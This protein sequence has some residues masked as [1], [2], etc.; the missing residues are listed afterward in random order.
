VRRR[1]AL[2]GAVVA[3]LGLLVALF[4]ARVARR[5]PGARLEMGR[6]KLSRLTEE[7]RRRLGSLEDRVLLTYYASDRARMPS[8]LRRVERDV[9]DLFEA[10]KGASRERL[11]YQIV[12]PDADPVARDDLARFAAKRAVAPF[13]ARSV[14]RDAW[15]EK[16]VWSTISIAYGPRPES[17]IPGVGPEHLERLQRLLVEHLDQMERPR[18]A[19]IALAAPAGYEQL[20]GFLAQKG[21][22]RTVDLDGGERI[23]P[24]ADCLFWMDPRRVDDARLAEL[25]RFLRRGRNA[26]LAGSEHSW[27][28][29]RGADGA[30]ALT[31]EPTGYPAG[32]L[33]AH[34]GLRA[35][36]GL[37]CDARGEQAYAGMAPESRP[38][39]TPFVVRCI[40]VD[41][42]FRG[43]RNQPNGNL[44][45]EVPTPFALDPE[46]LEERGWQ[47]EVLA[48][49][50]DKSWVEPLPRGP[51]PFAALRPEA[52]EP[53]PKQPLMVRLKPRDPW[54]G[55]VVLCAASTPFRD[56]YLQ[57]REG[58]AH[59]RL[60]RVLADAFTA[61]DRLVL[62]RAG[63]LAVEPIPAMGARSRAL[64][65]AFA[66]LLLPGALLAVAL[67][68]GAFARRGEP[69]PRRR[70][71]GPLLA[72][73]L[74]GVLVV[75]LLARAAGAFG[76]RADL[77][78]SGRNELSPQT[79]AIAARASEPVEAKIVFSP[80]ERLPP[81]MRRWSKR[82]GEALAEL[83]RAG[84]RLSVRT[85]DPDEL[86]EAE[87]KTLAAEGIEPFRVTT[88]DEE[89][90]TVRTVHA[91]LRLSS[92]GRTEVLRFRDAVSIENLEFRLA[93]AL[94]RLETGR[95]PL[96]AF[97]SD[98][99]RLSPAEAWDLQQAS[100]TPPSG[101]DAYAVARGLLEGCDY[102][103]VHVNPR[104][105]RP[106]E[107]PDAFVWLQP[108]RDVS[109]TYDWLARYL[110]RG[111]R[112]LLAAQHFNVQA[113]QY[114]GSGYK[115]VY[116]PQPQFPDVDLLYFPDLGIEMVRE[117]L[118]D[119]LKT[120]IAAETQ[121]NRAYARPDLE[122]Q[123]S[124]LPFLLRASAANFSKDSAVTRS[125]G[126]QAF[127]WGAYVR[128]DEAKL[129]A[130][131]LR[132]KPLITT[133]ARTWTFPWK[134]GWIPDEALAGP[135][136]GEGGQPSWLGK[137]ALAAE[138]EGD[139]PEPAEP[140]RIQ[141]KIFPGATSEPAASKPAFAASTPGAPGRLLLLGC[142][143]MFKNHRV[144]DPEF[145][146]DHLLLNAVASLAL[147]EDLAEIA[148]RRP[149]QR[150]FDFVE[151]QDRLRWR[152]IVL[153]GLPAA[154][155]LFGFLRAVARRRPTWVATP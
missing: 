67:L 108:R 138:I 155:L 50:S 54:E 43:W 13:R 84:A 153:A 144:L 102:R 98:A 55:A 97:A 91:A 45:F 75:G 134:G 103:V 116:W 85:V 120:R 70:A 74:A 16:T 133:S 9:T 140:L 73:A 20:R 154:L 96:V 111:G 23:P 25:D 48:T 19:A 2:E 127:V 47:A 66:V 109:A 60:A 24:D 117:V 4:D 49:S 69:S 88:K 123:T 42:D 149:E 31:V 131:G 14:E 21:E 38:A 129:R 148:A 68:R 114:R 33:L 18:R 110:H 137:L 136:R 132:A 142:S 27:E 106:P 15:S 135:P 39:P 1:G 62:A 89:V 5:F 78:E 80:P 86:D 29:R 82:I 26:L 92:R 59:E 3:V 12:D 152:G 81:S 40:G 151:P 76:A 95:R 10:L 104:D 130:H 36:Q 11:D 150:G 65:R 72:T 28:A 6:A 107:S 87:K 41:Q 46:A 146:G 121:V 126:D 37:L 53:V 99:P 63:A 147:P 145:R 124:A 17:T 143:E 64:W 139:F 128:T 83:R 44:L 56:G 51:V 125:L 93:F 77:S 32:A 100:L 71:G 105:P 7:T 94:W 119:E 8:Q 112:A 79:R 61:N 57:G 122:V 115:L 118:F 22:V 34:F 90:T 35:T 30:P 141:P 52:G 113:R 101:T 58:V